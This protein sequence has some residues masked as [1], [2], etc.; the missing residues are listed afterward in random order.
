[1]LLKLLERLQ[2]QDIDIA[3]I[4]LAGEGEVAL[5]IAAL[6]IPVQCLGM[7]GLLSGVSGWLS[8]LRRIRQFK[9]DIVQTWMYHADLIGGVAARL[10]GVRHV[11]WNIRNG[12]V[13]RQAKFFTRWVVKICAWSSR[14]IPESILNC[15]EQ[16]MKTHV[17]YGYDQMRMRVIPNGFDVTRF[18]PDVEARRSVREELGI[19][20]QSRLIGLVGRFHAQ[21]NHM[22]FIRMVGMLNR[23]GH[24]V[25][26][27][28]A[29]QGVDADN[30]QLMRAAAAEGIGSRCFFLGRRD[31][32]PR[33]M[34]ALDV[35]VSASDGEAFPNVLGEAMSCGVPC[36]A[37]DVGDSAL[38]IGDCGKVV[39][40]D[41]MAGLAVAV[42]EL[43]QLPLAQSRA[44]SEQAR[45]RIAGQFDLEAVMQRYYG[46]YRQLL[47]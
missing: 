41:D 37:T 27:L 15:S 4:G 10:C 13:D 9:P 11:V 12:V 29:G 32:V 22:G 1:M 47:S 31:D 16:A 3:V 38:I 35:L 39:Q 36:A 34:A 7:R 8:L 19:A 33:I 30:H 24:D 18:K 42:M 46:L 20:P 26:C 40:A 25:Y 14:V 44:L 28:C 21:K 5:K 43:L 6:G 23:Q 2:K 17:G 45:A